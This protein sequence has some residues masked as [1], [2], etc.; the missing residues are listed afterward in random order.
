MTGHEVRIEGVAHA[1]GHDDRVEE[2]GRLGHLRLLQVLVGPVEHDVGD[3][4]AEHVGGFGETVTGKGV[5]VVKIL[6]HSGELRSLSGENHGFHAGEN[7]PYGGCA[8][9]QS[10]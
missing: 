6:P 5:G 2:D 1:F 10:V 7:R 4:E 3:V 9:D 8:A